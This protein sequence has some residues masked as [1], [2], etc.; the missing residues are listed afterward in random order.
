MKAAIYARKSTLDDVGSVARQ[1]EHAKEYATKKGWTVDDRYVYSDTDISGAEFERRPGYMQLMSTLKPEP[2][3]QALIV[4]EESRIGREAIE[5]AYALKQLI[6]AGVRVFLY[7]EDRERTIDTPTEKILLAV[8]AY[9]DE[10][11]RE[12][13]RDRT[14]DALLHKA[15][16]GHVTGG[17]VFGY[18]NQEVC[19]PDGRRLYVKRVINPTEAEIVLT[20]FS[21]YAE[22]KGFRK[23]AKV[24][25]ERGALSPTPRRTG[26][27]RAWAPSSIREIIHRDLYRGLLV[28]GKVQKRDAWGKKRIKARPKEEWVQ[29]SVPELRI[30]SDELWESAHERLSGARGTYLRHQDGKLWGRPASGIESRYLLTSFTECGV[31]GGSLYVVKAGDVRVYRCSYNHLRGRKVCTNNHTLSMTRTNQAVLATLEQDILKPE[32]VERAVQLALERLRPQPDTAKQDSLNADLAIVQG[33]IDHLTKAIATGGDIP[34][35][36][37]AIKERE[38]RKAHIEDELRS[39]QQLEEVAQLDL[40]EIER[41]LRERLEQWKDLLQRHP[42]QAR[43]ILRKLLVG[44][45][46]FTPGENGVEFRG[47]AALGR[48]LEGLIRPRK[49]AKLATSEALV[50][51]AGF[52]PAAPCLKGRCSTRLS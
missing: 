18:D 16:A 28:W 50:T 27:P 3:F 25:N 11:E 19:G 37:A 12:R 9:G 39:L 33:E 15:K 13:A 20:I 32:V 34:S 35:L 38:T 7:M 41:D 23:I 46:V 17:R 40:K 51:R 14:W 52:E 42:A 43:Q 24:L 10:I 45:L 31:C 4:S 49:S 21:L 1:I 5:T 22:G 47:E 36:V 26:R 44:R 48:V 30:V 29:V 8:S 6:T 2:P